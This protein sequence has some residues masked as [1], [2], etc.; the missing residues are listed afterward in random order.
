MGYSLNALTDFLATVGMPST[1]EGDGSRHVTGVA[2]LEEAGA[3]EISFLSNPKYESMLGRTGA[4][5]VIV[6]KDQAIPEGMHVIRAPDPYAAVTAVIVRIYGYREH[7]AV[8]V[9]DRAVVHETAQ[10][11]A[12]ANIHHNVTIGANVRVGKNAVMYPG[13]Y[14][15]QDC[16][17]GDDC[18]LYPNVVIYPGCKLGDRVT[19]HAGTVIGEDG[20]G[21]APVEGRWHK[22]PQVGVTE[23]GDD[24]ELGANCAIDRATLGRTVIG[25]GTK[26][27]NLV[28]IGHGTKIGEHCM[29]VAQVGIAGSVNVGNNVTMAGKVG[30]AGHLEIGDRA[31]LGAMSGVMKNIPADMKVAGAPAMPI[32]TALRSFSMMEKLPD[33]ARQL[34]KLE[35]RVKELEGKL[36]DLD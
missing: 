35:A 8:G 25:A 3:D 11:G 16:E 36:G 32:Q 22:I 28:T 10:I 30:V 19:L 14:V 6:S 2:T 18:L 29:F 34:K 1:V 33:M 17:I 24:V 4:G 31:Q 26:F 13:T 5:A 12:N 15:F 21:Y 7:E 20:L 27:S 23:L 9:S